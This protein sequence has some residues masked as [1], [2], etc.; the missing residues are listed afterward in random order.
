MKRKD[1]EVR[2]DY[3]FK[4][5]EIILDLLSEKARN[6]YQIK[7]RIN[8]TYGRKLGWVTIK[9]HLDYLEKNERVFIYYE[10]DEG[11]KKSRIYKIKE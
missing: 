3:D 2:G 11:K 5:D 4:L 9:R 10:S 7:E 8:E 1:G 6:P